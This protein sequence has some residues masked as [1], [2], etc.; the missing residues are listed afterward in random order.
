[1]WHKGSI[2]VGVS[3]ELANFVKCP[4]PHHHSGRLHVEISLVKSIARPSI[5]GRPPLFTAPL[6]DPR[7]KAQ[8]ALCPRGSPILRPPEGVAESVADTARA[9]S[10]ERTIPSSP[11][12]AFSRLTGQSDSYMAR[13]GGRGTAT[14]S[15]DRM[16]TKTFVQPSESREEDMAVSASVSSFARDSPSERVYVIV[17]A[18]ARPTHTI[19]VEVMRVIAPPVQEARRRSRHREVR[20]V[21]VGVRY[22]LPKRPQR[23]QEAG[24][25]GHLLHEVVETEQVRSGL[26]ENFCDAEFG[27]AREGDVS[28][29]GAPEVRGR[30]GAEDVEMD[31]DAVVQ[32]EVAA[33]LVGRAALRGGRGQDFAQASRGVSPVEAPEAISDDGYGR[34]YRLCLSTASI[35]YRV[36]I[37]RLFALLSPHLEA[38]HLQHFVDQA[39]SSLR[40]PVAGP[41]LVAGDV[42]H[43]ERALGP[44]LA[45]AVVR[46][47]SHFATSAIT[48]I[49]TVT[50]TCTLAVLPPQERP[51]VS[52]SPPRPRSRIF[53]IAI[54]ARGGVPIAPPAHRAALARPGV[55]ERPALPGRRDRGLVEVAQVRRTSLVAVHDEAEVQDVVGRRVGVVEGRVDAFATEGTRSRARRRDRIARG[56]RAL[57]DG[58]GGGGGSDDGYSDRGLPR[59]RRHIRRRE[60]GCLGGYE[61]EASR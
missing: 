7:E 14:G 46:V 22:A 47:R 18:R 10:R 36:G 26:A 30:S 15:S 60:G 33:G 17:F 24:T 44:R 43:H 40:D 61:S 2:T 32:E 48:A 29:R 5:T 51:S 42:V 20:P 28:V 16:S 55:P 11:E 54:V 4:N 6:T 45:V 8:M 19:V 3:L 52:F 38:N 37:L 9:R 12:V 13:K 34:V 59:R 21:R 56:R 23:G 27:R 1:M 49:A 39:L 50:M 35:L 57:R 58:G 31:A 41:A 25:R 53:A